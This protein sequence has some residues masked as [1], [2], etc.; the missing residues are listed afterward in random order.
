MKFTIKGETGE[1]SL[2]A[3][4]MTGIGSPRVLI[5]EIEEEDGFVGQIKLAPRAVKMM[6]LALEA[7]E[8]V[9]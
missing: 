8:E 4:P 2:T 1:M 7:L 5:L 6:R 3:P 9:L